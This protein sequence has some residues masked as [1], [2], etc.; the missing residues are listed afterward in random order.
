M[1]TISRQVHIFWKKVMP[2]LDTKVL[3]KFFQ[4]VALKIRFPVPT[5]WSVPRSAPLA[6]PL[7][8][9][10]LSLVPSENYLS[11]N[12][13]FLLQPEHKS[14]SHFWPQKYVVTYLFRGEVDV[15]KLDFQTKR[16]GCLSSYRI[17]KRYIYIYI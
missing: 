6:A 11:L 2:T 13:S 12:Q 4:V 5:S 8:L 14:H 9:K 10:A 1:S 16:I 17:C 15:K 7:P 3:I